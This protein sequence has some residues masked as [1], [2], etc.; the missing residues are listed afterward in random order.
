[1]TSHERELL[2]ARILSGCSLLSVGDARY[3]LRPPTPLQQYQA[4]ALYAER[5]RCARDEGLLG[6]PDL[7]AW[8]LRVG[9][10]DE[11]S[12]DLLNSLPKEIDQFKHAL[13]QAQFRSGERQ[14][15]RK[16]L[17]VA[18]A[19]LA[20]LSARRH[21]HHHTSAEGHAALCRARYLF[22]VCLHTPSGV[23]VFGDDQFWDAR[24]GVLEQAVATHEASRPTAEQ[25]RELARTEP[26][27]SVWA[28]R[29]AEGSV[30]GVPSSQYTHEQRVLVGYSLFYDSVYEHPHCPPDD[31]L[32]DDDCLDG[33]VIEQ[34]K[35]REAQQGA[36]RGD[37]LLSDRVK[38]AQEVFLVAD[39]TEDA[40]KIV[41]LNDAHGRATQKMRFEHLRQHGEVHELEMPDTRRRL[42]MEFN[43]KM[44]GG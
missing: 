36:A 17:A 29:K 43:R 32:A 7:L 5:L 11:A 20:E 16:L 24:S 1:M 2:A 35:Q 12:E 3:L 22:A 38:D 9:L 14:R 4:E 13:W 42:Q 28:C 6:E 30:L 21:A 37:A 10:W 40:R 27:R 18:R 44:T 39:T 25:M 23:R 26:W 15:L 41:D 33:W 19:K 31:V 34:R 8:M